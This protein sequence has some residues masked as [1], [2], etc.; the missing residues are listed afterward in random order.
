MSFPCLDAQRNEGRAIQRD[1]ELVS[2]LVRRRSVAKL[3]FLPGDY[4]AIRVTGNSL[5]Y[6]YKAFFWWL[7][8]KRSPSPSTSPSLPSGL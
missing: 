4:K 3:F 1:D 8:E 2:Y 7:Y 5:L 6:E